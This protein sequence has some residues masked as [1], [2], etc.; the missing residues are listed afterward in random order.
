MECR[1]GTDVETRNHSV[2][3]ERELSTVRIRRLYAH[4]SS[5]FL[6]VQRCNQRRLYM[7]NFYS[8]TDDCE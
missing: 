5:F 8:I 4:A 7:V 2:G 3:N 6:T 1:L